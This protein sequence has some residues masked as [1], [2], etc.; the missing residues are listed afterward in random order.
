MLAFSLRAI[1]KYRALGDDLHLVRMMKITRVGG[2]YGAPCDHLDEW[3]MQS[4]GAGVLDELL[5]ECGLAIDACS[6]RSSGRW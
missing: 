6:C 3:T 2:W 1:A 4:V 5:A